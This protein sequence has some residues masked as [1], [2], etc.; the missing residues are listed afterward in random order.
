MKIQSFLMCLMI[1][2]ACLFICGFIVATREPVS[3]AAPGVRIW[4]AGSTE[5]IQRANRSRL[6]HTGVWMREPEGF[7]SR[8]FGESTFLS[9]WWLRLTGWI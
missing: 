7:A 2:L 8:A 6:P 4:A 3:P 5:K 1:A 9:R